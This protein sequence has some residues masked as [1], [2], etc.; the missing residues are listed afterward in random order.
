MATIVCILIS[1]VSADVIAS[2]IGTMV[3]LKV[4]EYV[5]NSLTS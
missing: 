1:R 5:T 2:G 4:F 3:T